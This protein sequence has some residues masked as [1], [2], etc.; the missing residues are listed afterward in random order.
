MSAPAASGPAGPP[1]PAKTAKSP[2]ASRFRLARRISLIVALQQLPVIA[3]AGSH[4]QG[5]LLASHSRP[6]K[7]MRGGQ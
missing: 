4:T 1:F 6:S 3:P 7:S 2:R 5:Y